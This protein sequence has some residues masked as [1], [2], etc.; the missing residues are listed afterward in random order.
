MLEGLALRHVHL[1]TA[2]GTSVEH[3]FGWAARRGLSLGYTRNP[4]SEH[5]TQGGRVASAAVG[6]WHGVVAAVNLHIARQAAAYIGLSGSMWSQLAMLTLPLDSHSKCAGTTVQ[7]LSR[8]RG[9]V[10]KTART[11]HDERLLEFECPYGF[12]MQGRVR[13]ALHTSVDAARSRQLA[14]AKGR[15]QQSWRWTQPSDRRVTSRCV[16]I[17]VDTPWCP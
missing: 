5:D 12:G 1:Q 9:T 11:T 16:A 4:R 2:S 7:T 3:A 17:D 13:V 8:R 6:M 14:S 10:Y 15:K